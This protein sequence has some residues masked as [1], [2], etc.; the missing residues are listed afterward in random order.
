MENLIDEFATFFIAGQET[1]SN[2]LAF[3]F[4]ELGRNPEVLEK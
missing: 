3:V 1:T 4:M 2:A